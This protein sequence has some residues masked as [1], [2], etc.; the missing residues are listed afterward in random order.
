MFYPLLL[1]GFFIY[2]LVTVCYLWNHN[3]KAPGQNIELNIFG[4]WQNNESY[5]KVKENLFLHIS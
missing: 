3:K 5:F 1:S 2:L 4:S